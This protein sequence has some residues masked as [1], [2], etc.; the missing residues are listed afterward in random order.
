MEAN[1]Y[2][3]ELGGIPEAD[4]RTTKDGSIICLHDPTP[5]RTTTVPEA[6][7]DEPITS[8]TLEEVKQWDAGIKFAA[9]FKGAKIPTLEEVFRAMQ[10]RPERQIYLDLKDV[11]LNQLGRMIDQYQVN[12]QV[13]FTHKHQ[14]NCIQMKQITS[15]VRTMLW[16]MGNVDRIKQTYFEVRNNGFTG[17]NQV[18]IHLRLGE[19]RTDWPFE[20]EQEYVKKVIAETSAAGIDFEVFLY[21]CEDACVHPLLDE[22]IR[23]F[24]TD[25]PSAFLHSVHRWM[26]KN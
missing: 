16:I 13:I 8:F 11:D 21:S 19:S 14:Q 9:K 17:L 15:D 1:K 5:A 24:A 18:Q 12:E 4:I 26:K 23:W 25:E 3:W 10:E 20:L 22:G 6:V 7:K 2:T